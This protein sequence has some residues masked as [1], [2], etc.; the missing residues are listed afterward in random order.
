MPALDL[1]FWPTEIDALLEATED[2]HR[3]AILLNF[4][5]H[6]LL[7]IS[8]LWPE[9]LT[10]EMTVEH[11]VYRMGDLSGAMT[12]HD[13]MDAVRALYRGLAEAGATVMMPIAERMIVTDYG[14][15]GEA[16]PFGSFGR[17]AAL[18]AAGLDA[19]PSANYLVEVNV[20]YI[21]EYD[22]HA[23][24]TAERNYVD[25]SSVVLRRVDPADVVTTAQAREFLAPYLANPPAPW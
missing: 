2:P 12:I 7:E 18:A 4:R 20:M 10:P 21:F 16:M 25:N 8:G 1:T 24:L 19:D 11:P 5:R 14:V 6:V 3:R 17:G 13:G 15:V 9:I 22:R 23:R